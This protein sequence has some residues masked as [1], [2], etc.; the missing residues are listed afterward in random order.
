VKVLWFSNTCANAAGY[1]ND[2]FVRGGWLQSLDRHIQEHV[3]LHVAFYYHKLDS[4]FKYGNTT[5][6]PINPVNW[7]LRTIK[8]NLFGQVVDEEELSD[9]LKIIDFVKP[10]L[11]H[12]HGTES[13]FRCILNK[14]KIPVVFS[15]QGNLTVCAHKYT[16]GIELKYLSSHD[17]NLKGGIKNILFSKSFKY[18]RKI[19]IK[20]SLNEL[21][22]LQFCK[23][24]IG[25]T[26][27]DRRISSVMAPGRNYYHNDEILRDIFYDEKWSLPE[28]TD[29]FIIQSIAGNSPLKGFETICEALFEINRTGI[30]NVEWRVAGIE[31][32]NL[33]VKTVKKKLR[34]KFPSSGLVLLGNI[35]EKELLAKLKEAHLFVMASHIE[36]SS[37]SLCEAMILGMPCIATCA[38]G[39]SSLL[40]DKLEGLIIQD[41]DPWAMAGAILELYNNKNQAVKYGEF[42]RKRALIRHNKNLIIEELIGIYKNIISH[43]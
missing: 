8:N 2:D 15:I 1:L 36:N 32:S 29:K 33:I 25:R 13:P 5:Y 17:Y 34:K 42:A 3:D 10:D 11:I 6:H 7:K 22:D 27:W 21:R 40:N 43:K 30:A 20:N 26:D 18:A 24:V 19:L 31:D 28:R 12:I 9:Y 14:I 39:T 35:K 4:A 41:G 23:N 37:N 38:G 16:S